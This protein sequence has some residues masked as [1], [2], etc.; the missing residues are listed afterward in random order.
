MQRYSKGVLYAIITALFWGVLA[1]A[2][3]VAVEKVDPVTIVWF[4]FTLA[5]IPLFIWSIFKRPSRLRLMV[6]PPLLLIIAALALSWN[7]L[8]FNLGVKYTSPG[9]AQ[10]FVQTGQILLAL[11][12]IFFFNERFTKLQALGFFLAIAGLMLFY[13]Q[14]L[15]NFSENA[16]E[17]NLGIIII[18]SGAFTWALYAV[19]QKK[20]VVRY[21][22]LSLNL[23]LFGLPMILYLP[24]VD[25]SQLHE[26]NWLWWLLMAFLGFNTLVAYTTLALCLRHLEASKASIILIMNPVITFALMAMLAWL[27]VSW[28]EPERMSL[29]SVAGAIIVLAGALLVILKP[30]HIG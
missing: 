17:Y 26:L 7:Y 10:L 30:R 16:G 1:V 12:G 13:N 18:L 14:Q 27:E 29:L 9:N 22:A 28:I 21:S 4:R 3:K 6:K 23:F 8:A 25:F 20:L 24:F 11:A 5:F 19:I 15:S 2:L